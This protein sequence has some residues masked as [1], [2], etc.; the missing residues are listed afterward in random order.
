MNPTASSGARIA[1]LL[2]AG[3]GLAL[4]ASLTAVVSLGKELAVA[5]Q[6]GAGHQL[7]AYLAAFTVVTFL[8]TTVAFVLQSTF[9]PTFLRARHHGEGV[10]RSF[11]TAVI[12]VL[13]LFLLT[14]AAAIGLA[15]HKLLALL[16]PGFTPLTA[17]EAVT[18]TIELLPLV[19]LIGLNELLKSL[20]NAVKS[21]AFPAATQALPS[22]G[23]LVSVLSFSAKIGVGAIAAGWVLGIAGQTLLLV[24][25]CHRKGLR[26][27][28]RTD[29]RSADTR[30]LGRLSLPYLAVALLPWAYLV[31]DQHLA[32]RL[33]PGSISVL[34][35]ADKIFRLPLVIL[36]A[37]IYT[38][39][40]PFLSEAAVQSRMEDFVGLVD[41]M[42][43]VSVFLLLPLGFAIAILREPL[44]TLIYQR[45]SF[46]AQAASSTAGVLMYLGL[47]VPVLGIWYIYDRALTALSRTP[48]LMFLAAGAILAKLILS[49]LLVPRMGLV[50]LPLATVMGFG[51]AI[52]GMHLALKRAMRVDS[53][54]QWRA[55]LRTSFAGTLAAGVLWLG[56]YFL[57]SS[58]ASHA[59][60]VFHLVTVI[61]VA[62]ASYVGFATLLGVSELKALLAARDGITSRVVSLAKSFPRSIS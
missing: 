52:L 57:G 11:S 12:I 54:I 8:P 14:S 4:A 29:I 37:A 38:S 25:E 18:V 32:S 17:R 10:A 2:T 61:A 27:I 33:G 21:F 50:G 51:L 3:S 23:A 47:L 9:I 59:Q 19:W 58:S 55:L 53:I 20:L 5:R 13:S 22:L 42:I 41:R 16:A 26:L 7:D 15:S 46:G 43:R 44:V 30:A 49:L 1:R 6:F 60:V 56:W 24:R 39:M 35:Y 62:M 48:I 28:A 45:G 40:H 31:I 34:G 36:I